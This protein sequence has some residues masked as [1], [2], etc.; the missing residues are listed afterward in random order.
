MGQKSEED[1]QDYVVPGIQ[2]W[3]DGVTLKPGVT[4]QVRHRDS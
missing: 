4:S 3:L 1:V 2:P